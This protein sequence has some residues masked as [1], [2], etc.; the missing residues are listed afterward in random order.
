MIWDWYMSITIEFPKVIKLI[1]FV[2]NTP[3]RPC[4]FTTKNWVEANDDAPGTYNTNSQ[5]KLKTSML[6]S[7]L[8]SYSDA[9]VLAKGM[10]KVTN[11]VGAGQSE[12][13]ND[14]NSAIEIFE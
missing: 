4:G 12:N 2:G 6:K 13:I 9:S 11:T 3:Y 7:I 1:N 14:N 8:C 5:T 10:I